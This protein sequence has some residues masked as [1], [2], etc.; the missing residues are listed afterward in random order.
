MRSGKRLIGSRSGERGREVNIQTSLACIAVLLTA[1]GGSQPAPVTPAN[2]PVKPIATAPASRA[3]LFVEYVVI[4]E[5]WVMKVM[6]A[7]TATVQAWTAEPE[8]QTF[9]KASPEDREKAYRKWRAPG[10]TAQLATAL[11]NRL[12]TGTE[13]RLAI[14]E[15]VSSVLGELAASDEWRPAPATVERDELKATR[16]P[17]GAKAVLSNFADGA[18]AGDVMDPIAAAGGESVV[19]RAVDAKP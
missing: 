2:V 18:K 7:E 6:P 11:R 5:A 9:A 4:R 15:S 12:K 10:L 1:C 16:L 13:T 19:A 3:P 14:A 17:S 8:N